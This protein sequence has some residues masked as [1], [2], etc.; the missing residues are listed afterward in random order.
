M[1]QILVYFFRWYLRRDQKSV[2][3]DVEAGDED[4]SASAQEEGHE[5]DATAHDGED[6]ERV[7][8]ERFE[9]KDEKSG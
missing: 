2:S 5:S 3:D 8:V 7:P 4:Q 1:A 6:L 9:K